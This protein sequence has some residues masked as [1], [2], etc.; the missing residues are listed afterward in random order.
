MQIRLCVLFVLNSHGECEYQRN[1]WKRETLTHQ[2]CEM[3]IMCLYIYIY[4]LYNVCVI[5][6]RHK[7]IIQMNLLIIDAQ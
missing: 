2:T 6:L 3:Y 4:N 1:S 7:G 5:V